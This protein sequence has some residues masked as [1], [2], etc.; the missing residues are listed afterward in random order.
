MQSTRIL[1]VALTFL[2][3]MFWGLSLRA[4][5]TPAVPAD[6]I[7]L[8]AN[9]FEVPASGISDI[10]VLATLMEGKLV[11]GQLERLAAKD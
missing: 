8:S 1:S 7:L 6:L 2:L 3:T 5:E 11:Y 10:T 9:L 4:D